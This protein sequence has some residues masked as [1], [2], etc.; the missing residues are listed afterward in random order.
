MILRGPAFFTV[1]KLNLF[2]LLVLFLK[3]L[4]MCL[5]SNSLKHLIP[6]VFAQ[7][8][9]INIFFLCVRKGKF[10]S[11]DKI[12]TAYEDANGKIKFDGEEY[13]RTIRATGCS[14]LVSSGR[15]LSCT[16]FR[17]SLRSMYSRWQKKSQSPKKFSNNL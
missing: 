7:E 9:L 3:L 11:V 16:K 4:I 12:I 5:F 13:D 15:C 8:I 1:M 17:S 14:I 2:L 10:F 6:V